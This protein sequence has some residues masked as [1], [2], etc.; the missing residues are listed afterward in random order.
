MCIWDP[1]PTS[2]TDY[3]EYS[4]DVAGNVTQ[5]RRRDGQLIGTH[6]AKAVL[7]EAGCP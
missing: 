2:A 3:E 1:V 6:P 4:Y 7:R 5:T